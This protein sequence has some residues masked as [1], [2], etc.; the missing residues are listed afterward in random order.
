[1]PRPYSDM[2]RAETL[3]SV[4]SGIKCD[5]G[6]LELVNQ[7]KN[8]S[9][10]GAHFRDRTNPGLSLVLERHTG[11]P[12]KS[13]DLLYLLYLLYLSDLLKQHEG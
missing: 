9:S 7:D 3:F 10:Q 1:M 6:Q 11:F 8:A 12:C 2:G 5:S 4:G 13:Y